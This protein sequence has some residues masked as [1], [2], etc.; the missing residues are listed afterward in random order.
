MIGMPD[1]DR[2]ARQEH[3]PQCLV[4]RSL[5]AL[6]LLCP[7][8]VRRFRCYG[9]TLPVHGVPSVAHRFRVCASQKPEARNPKLMRH[10]ARGLEAL[11]AAWRDTACAGTKQ[12]KFNPNPMLDDSANHI[13]GGAMTSKAR[14]ESN[15]RAGP[16]QV[17]L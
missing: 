8:W 4:K 13:T 3:L 17:R 10:L 1:R 7:Q 6:A 9:L 11:L 14:T 2:I 15:L 12:V 16:K 5:T